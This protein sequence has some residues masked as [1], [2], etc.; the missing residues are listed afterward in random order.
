MIIEMTQDHNGV[1][2]Y[3]DPAENDMVF[4]LEAISGMNLSAY[5]VL[6]NDS[7]QWAG[8]EVK[9]K[10]LTG[11]RQDLGRIYKRHFD[12][13]ERL[14]L[15]VQ[16]YHQ[17]FDMVRMQITG[18]VLEQK[19]VR[20][21]A[22][23]KEAAKAPRPNRASPFKQAVIDVMRSNKQNCKDFK[24]FMDM[25]KTQHLA[26]LTIKSTS[27]ENRYLISDENGDLGSTEYAW[28][29]LQSMYAQAN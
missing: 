23:P 1:W 13:T 17:A 25:W 12:D 10:H 4:E 16:S 15:Q 8:H 19:D 28:D 14:E 29:S 27:D 20:R 7:P 24:T 18:M 21:K 11:L 26:G 2:L 6:L 22:Q 9:Q 3:N 5:D